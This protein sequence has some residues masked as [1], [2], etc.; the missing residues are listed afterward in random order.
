VVEETSLGQLAATYNLSAV[1][2]KVRSGWVAA[3]LA[4]KYL[5]GNRFATGL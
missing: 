5:L 4:L 1:Q 2:G 3:Q